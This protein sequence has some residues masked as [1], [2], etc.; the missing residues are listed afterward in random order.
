MRIKTQVL[1]HEGRELRSERQR[2]LQA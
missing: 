2:T 1:S